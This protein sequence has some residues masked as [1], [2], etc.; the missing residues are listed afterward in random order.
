M[1]INEHN[2]IT[3]PKVKKLDVAEQ[4]GYKCKNYKFEFLLH[5]QALGNDIDKSDKSL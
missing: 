1:T 2:C 3:L 5:L 4:L